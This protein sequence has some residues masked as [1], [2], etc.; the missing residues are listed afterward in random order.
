MAAAKRDRGTM[1]VDLGACQGHGKCY[2]L[3]PKLFR[4]I[5][6]D[7]HSEY[8]GGPIEDDQTAELAQRA[9]M[10]CPEFAVRREL[11]SRG[12]TPSGQPTTEGEDEER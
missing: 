11:P 1:S 2:G 8:I 5:D 10:A 3:A 6:D 4:P 9:Q 7:G 12:V